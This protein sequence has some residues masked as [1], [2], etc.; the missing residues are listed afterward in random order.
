MSNK[1]TSGVNG[2]STAPV[3][4]VA[5]FIRF[6]LLWFVSIYAD[7]AFIVSNPCEQIFG[8]PSQNQ[9]HEG[10][11]DINKLDVC[12]L[13]VERLR[14]HGAWEKFSERISICQLMQIAPLVFLKNR[15][16]TIQTSTKWLERDLERKEFLSLSSFVITET[17]LLHSECI[18]SSA[19]NAS[20]TPN[21]SFIVL[22]SSDASKVLATV[23]Y[24]RNVGTLSRLTTR[25]SSMNS[26]HNR[27]NIPDQR[28]SWW[29]NL[30]M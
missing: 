24:H 12:I 20:K 10:S 16:L 2:R 6:C 27:L 11:N 19:Q 29:W 17:F 18:L 1:L 8:S 30:L 5:N 13:R 3:P 23:N 4:W 7:D 26:I 21:K 15:A 22:V 9:S 14:I 25:L 28:E